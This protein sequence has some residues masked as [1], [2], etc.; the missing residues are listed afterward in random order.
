[1]SDKPQ[2]C[3][4][5]HLLLKEDGEH[6]LRCD[7]GHVMT[8][9]KYAWEVLGVGLSNQKEIRCPYCNKLFAIGDYSDRPQEFK[10]RSCKKT[11]TFLRIS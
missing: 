7:N 6:L 9:A 1:M 10:C 4:I 8:L 2:S 5:C 11:S 3:P